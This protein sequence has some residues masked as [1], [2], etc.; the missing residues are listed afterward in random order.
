MAERSSTFTCTQSLSPGVL[1]GL[2]SME[3]LV[4]SWQN[5]FMGPVGFQDFS[6]YYYDNGSTVLDDKLLLHQAPPNTLTTMVSTASGSLSSSEAIAADNEL[7][8]KVTEDVDEEEEED[9]EEGIKQ[10][11]EIDEDDDPKTKQMKSKEKQR[12][13]RIAFMTKSDVDHL[14]D[15]YRWRK[16]GQKAVKNS[17]FPRSYYRCTYASCNVKKRVERSYTDPTLVM[18]TYEGQHA[19]PSP[20]L[21]PGHSGLVRPRREYFAMSHNEVKGSGSHHRQCSPYYSPPCMGSSA[22]PGFSISDRGLLEDVVA[23]HIMKENFF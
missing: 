13:P 8:A 12:E 17:P 6:S 20:L 23:S 1:T 15:G 22:M 7:Q 2:V 3:D 5:G 9:E 11:G 10:Y 14:E 16:Y 18:T 19:H 4:S 21:M